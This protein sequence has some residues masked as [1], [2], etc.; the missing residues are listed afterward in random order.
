MSEIVLSP[1]GAAGATPPPSLSVVFSFANEEDV[2][3]EAIGRLRAV[4]GDECARGRL[5]RYELIFVNDASKDRSQE[6]LKEAA[7]GHDD[8]RVI[9][10]ARNFGISPCALAGM[11][12]STGDLVVYMDVDLQDPPEVISD[13]LRAQQET[14]ADVVHTIRRSR[15]GEGRLKMAI[16]WLGY[17]ILHYVSNI[18]IRIEAG[19]FKLLTRRAVNEVIKFRE[20]RPFLRGLV[21]WVGFKQTEIY[22][23]RQARGAGKTKFPVLGLKVIRNFFDSALISFSDVPLQAATLLGAIISLGAFLYFVYVIVAKFCGCNMPGWSAMMATILFL[24]GTQLLFMG[25]MGLYIN[26]I[27]LETKNRP[28][29]VVESTFGFPESPEKKLEGV[30]AAASQEGPNDSP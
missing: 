29:Y 8:I 14:G 1:I 7:H 18:P 19:D 26:A 23:D 15:A 24:G 16:T 25:I 13:L 21:A 9:N 11:E 4:L 27:Y 20:K 3:P 28:N 17:R 2:L 30:S 10:M 12:Y 5:S 22:Y 6:I